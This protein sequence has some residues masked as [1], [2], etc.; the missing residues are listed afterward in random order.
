MSI[1]V[2][3]GKRSLPVESLTD[4]HSLVKRSTDVSSLTDRVFDNT[5]S[6]VKGK[7]KRSRNTLSVVNF[8]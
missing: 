8:F 7:N 2:E 1:W 5:F 4:A 6:D 3:A